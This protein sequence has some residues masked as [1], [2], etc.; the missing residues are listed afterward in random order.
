MRATSSY[1]APRKKQQKRRAAATFLL[2]SAHVV[3]NEAFVEDADDEAA[4]AGLET[5]LDWDRVCCVLLPPQTCPLCRDEPA[6]C[7]MVLPCGHALCAG[8]VVELQSRGV[9][10]CLV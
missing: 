1:G 8:C 9:G 10:A 2:S 7:P 6:A 4:L 5:R 3:Y